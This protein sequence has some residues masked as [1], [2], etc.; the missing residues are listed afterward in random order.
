ME[1]AAS[2]APNATG[3]EIDDLII[4]ISRL[5]VTRNGSDIPLPHLSFNLLVALARAAPDPVSL[6]QLAERVWPGLVA[7]PETISQ[8]VKLVRQALG[9]DSHTPRY[10]GGVRGRGYRIVAAVRPLARP[11]DQDSAHEEPAATASPPRVRS[12]RAFVWR[13]GAALA[14]A[15]LL[16]LTVAGLLAGRSPWTWHRLVRIESLAVLPL[17]NLSGDPAQDYF[18]QGMTDELI[19]E[20]ARISSLRVISRTSVVRYQGTQKTLPQIGKELRV[21]AV[22]QGAVVTAGNRLRITAQLIETDTDKH[23]WAD[24]YERDVRDV[25][26]LQSEVASAIAKQVNATLTGDEHARL[27]RSAHVSARAQ[28]AYLRGLFF[29]NK[30]TEEGMKKSVGYFQEA[31]DA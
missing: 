11:A 18:A 17:A 1:Q 31:I 4:D 19:T 9:D 22:V 30:W 29:W 5:R 6:D 23:L 8:R 27:S 15:G 13:A 10:I 21:D 16:I 7:T 3:Y 24:S 20:L 12:G 25:L 14:L 26:A 2:D 28:D